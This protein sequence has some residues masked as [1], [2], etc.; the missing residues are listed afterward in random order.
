MIFF[1]EFRREQ[2]KPVIRTTHSI[3][4]HAVSNCPQNKNCKC[5]HWQQ[6][7]TKYEYKYFI[8]V[9]LK[10]VLSFKVEGT[11]FIVF[12]L[13]IKRSIFLFNVNE[14]GD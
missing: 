11:K 14:F 3:N 4:Y 10:R 6:L 5:S 2:L 1:S 9:T 13:R 8:P 7:A 12:K